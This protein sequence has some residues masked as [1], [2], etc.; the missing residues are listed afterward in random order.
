MFVFPVHL[1]VQE[2]A[3][4]I[5]VIRW[6]PVTRRALFVPML[7]LWYHT[8]ALTLCRMERFGNERRSG[9]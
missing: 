9:L 5:L 6:S 2:L 1:A 4:S 8:L 7:R 3:R